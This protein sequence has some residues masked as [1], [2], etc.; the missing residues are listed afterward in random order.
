MTLFLVWIGITAIAL[1]LY[2]VILWVKH[3]RRGR[4]QAK[5]TVFFLLFVFIPTVPLTFFAANLLTRSA[6]VLLLPG[7]G[8]ALETSL[9]TIRTQAERCGEH[10]LEKYPESPAWE[11]N[12]LERE[13]VHYIGLFNIS[14]DGE[15]PLRIV[16]SSENPMPTDW[17]PQPS[18]LRYAFQNGRASDLA[19]GLDEARMTYV[20]KHDDQSVVALVYPISQYIIQAKDEITR[21]IGIYNTLGLLKESIIQRNLIWALAVLFI[22]GL[23]ILSIIVA[24]NLSRGI[25]EPVKGLVAGMHQVA[26]G[27][28]DGRVE[29]SAKD[30][31]RFLV[32]SFN[33]M[34]N[35]LN[36]SRQ[37]LIA[38]ERMAAW[39]QVAR[40][41]SH[42][43]KNSLT[44]I[45]LSLRRLHTHLRKESMTENVTQSL[46][47]VEEELNTLQS[48]AAEFSE[49]AR[50]PEP[51]KASV[52]LNNIVQSTV[53]LMETSAGHVDLRMQLASDLPEIQAD[54]EQIKR[55][56]INLIKNGLEAS[57]DAGTVTIATRRARSDKFN[58]ELEI[59]DEGEGMDEETLNQVFQ[60]YFTTKKKGTGLGLAIVQ[61]IVEDHNGNIHVD[62]IKGK[63]TKVAVQI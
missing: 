23:T 45:S 9:E 20:R 57:H 44:P 19:S 1:I 41:I 47:T 54:R 27:E 46:R 30:E 16:R 33:Q 6:E 25:S 21:A 38:A 42:E 29:T 39:Q 59:T 11:R 37:K 63:F 28:L 50:M 2:V 56:L 8:S 24:R 10:F 49:F 13:G 36:T 26:E 15:V 12:V 7:I 55:L 31:F 5:L 34:V 51:Q 43:I 60:P 62:S 52:D 3:Q 22:V 48:M 14:S 32:D 61:K 58:I 35:D 18:E 4:F 53:R 40:Q 17:N